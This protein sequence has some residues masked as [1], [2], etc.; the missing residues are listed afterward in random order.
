[1]HSVLGISN[2][3][4]LSTLVITTVVFDIPSVGSGS[5]H[6]RDVHEYPPVLVGVWG[7]NWTGSRT[8]DVAIQA[9]FRDAPLAMKRSKQRR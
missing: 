7:T 1:M 6:V 5:T 8:I 2:A 3:L 4:V 9:W